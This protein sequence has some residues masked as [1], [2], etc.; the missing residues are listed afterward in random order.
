MRCCAR[1]SIFRSGFD[2]SMSCSMGTTS[3]IVEPPRKENLKIGATDVSYP[4]NR[5]PKGIP[6][7]PSLVAVGSAA[8]GPQRLTTD[9]SC[10]LTHDIDWLLT[11]SII[12]KTPRRW[13]CV[14]QVGSYVCGIHLP[15]EDSRH[16]LAKARWAPISTRLQR[17]CFSPQVLNWIRVA[18]D[19]LSCR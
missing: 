1:V 2:K 8:L 11:H 6:Q 18:K 19:L 16:G 12:E 17:R 3:T 9:D 14:T 4:P 10:Y 7:G 5:A 15:G 13:P